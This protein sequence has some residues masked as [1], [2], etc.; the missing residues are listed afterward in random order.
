[1]AEQVVKNVR[2]LQIVELARLADE[3]AGGE[4]AIGHVLEEDVVGHHA[5]HGDD[6][7]AGLLFHDVAQPLE[8]GISSALM[9]RAFN[10]SI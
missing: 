1:M 4:A 9:G 7:P 3:L 10:P 5:G 8:I 2:F 6:A